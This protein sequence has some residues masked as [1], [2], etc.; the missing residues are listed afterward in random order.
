MWIKIRT[1]LIAVLLN[2][3]TLKSL[4]SGA[5]L[6]ED[7]CDAVAGAIMDVKA[8]IDTKDKRYLN[9]AIDK[10]QTLIKQRGDLISCQSLWLTSYKEAV[11]GLFFIYNVATLWYNISMEDIS[12]TIQIIP[13]Y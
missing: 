3:V 5:G 10:L 12:C 11:K 2:E 6:K 4:A 7:A 9:A 8:F 13:S 1:V